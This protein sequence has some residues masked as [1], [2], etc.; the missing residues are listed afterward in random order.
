MS[1]ITEA[2]QGCP[3]LDYLYFLGIDESTR[4]GEE[5]KSL[6]SRARKESGLVG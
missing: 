4:I 5:M 2:L 1:D 6:K 3:N